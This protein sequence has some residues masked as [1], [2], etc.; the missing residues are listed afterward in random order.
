MEPSSQDKHR[1]S[2][3]SSGKRS[4]DAPAEPAWD[5]LLP[6]EWRDAVEAPLYF[7]SYSEY[8]IYA[9]RS[10]GYDADDQPCFTTY[11]FALTRLVM[12]DDEE[13]YE[14]IS[15]SEQL[16]AWRL[17]D[18]RWLVFRIAS[19]GPQPQ[20]RGFYAISPEMPR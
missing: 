1:T 9:Q 4:A 5:A 2:R 18:E 8:E 16:A 13:F 12:D 14:E 6:A 20:P 19:P 7:R 10:V 15:R 11:R 3:T 17:R